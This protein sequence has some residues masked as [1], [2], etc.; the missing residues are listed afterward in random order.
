[1]S[2]DTTQDAQRLMIYS[3][4]KK[5]SSTIWLLFLFFG[6]SYGSLDSIGLQ[7]LFYI[8]AGGFGIWWII[9]LFTLGGAIKEY[10]KK[11]AIMAG[12]N[13]QQMVSLGLV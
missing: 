12:L 3:S 9:R 13:P 2:D 7:L 10:N 5:E 4:T 8:T 6:W 11:Q 1:M